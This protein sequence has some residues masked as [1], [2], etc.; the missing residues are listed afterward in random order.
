VDKREVGIAMH[1]HDIW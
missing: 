1:E